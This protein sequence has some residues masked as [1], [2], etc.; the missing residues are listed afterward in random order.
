M[1]VST[2]FL[3]GCVGD[4]DNADDDA[5]PNRPGTFPLHASRVPRVASALKILRGLGLGLKTEFLES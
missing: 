2:A 4:R 5:G 3:A 1:R